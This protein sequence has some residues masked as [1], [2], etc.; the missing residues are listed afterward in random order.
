MPEILFDTEIH[1]CSHT[2]NNKAIS[3]ITNI[4]GIFQVF[5]IRVNQFTVIKDLDIYD[6]VGYGIAHDEYSM[7]RRFEC[8]EGPPLHSPT[9]NPKPETPK[10]PRHCGRTETRTVG[11]MEG[12]QGSGWEAHALYATQKVHAHNASH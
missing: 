8:A 2:V 12:N 4:L 6:K 5:D 7:R 11:E 9:L 1:P 3:S 10:I